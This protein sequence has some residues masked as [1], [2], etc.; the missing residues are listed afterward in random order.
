MAT[1][2]RKNFANPPCVMSCFFPSS[3]ELPGRGGTAGPVV[4]FVRGVLRMGSGFLHHVRVIACDQPMND[5][6]ICK[7]FRSG[8]SF[9]SSF[10][11]VYW[12]GRSIAPR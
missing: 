2:Q 12:L 6:S 9:V 1:L 7:R 3:S 4:H 11:V 5:L 10:F 8:R